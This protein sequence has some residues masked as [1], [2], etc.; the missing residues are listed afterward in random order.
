MIAKYQI[1]VPCR[2]RPG[3]NGGTEYALKRHIESPILQ[4]CKAS[5]ISSVGDREL[6]RFKEGITYKLLLL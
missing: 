1:A 4:N 3:Q 2:A 5:L 6:F